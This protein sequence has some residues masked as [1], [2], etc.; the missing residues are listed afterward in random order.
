VQR[1]RTVGW[2]ADRQIGRAFKLGGKPALYR[3]TV[4]FDS[5]RGKRL[6]SFQ[7]YFR[8]V[9]PTVHRRLALNAPSYQP[10]QTVFA[11]VENFGTEVAAYGVPFAIERLDAGGWGIAPES[12]DG[13]WILP[14]LASGPGETG[15]CTGFLIPPEMPPGHYRMS[16]ELIRDS[17]GETLTA[18]FDVHP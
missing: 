9:E 1:V 2:Q 10:G 7:R 12:P 3:L 4:V 15:P 14:M 11:R 6:A 8:V 16:K 5:A 17:A 13:S 18:E